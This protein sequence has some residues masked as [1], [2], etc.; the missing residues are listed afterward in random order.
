MLALNYGGRDEILHA[1]K[2]MLK[3]QVDPEQ[4]NEALMS[5][6]LYTAGIP[7]PDLLI[8]TSGEERISNF[9]TWQSVY[10]ELYFPEVY[11]PDF[12]EDELRKAI[13][14]FEK[15]DQALR[16]TQ[17]QLGIDQG[18][19]AVPTHK[20]CFDLHAPRPGNDLP[21]RVGVLCVHRSDFTGSG[22]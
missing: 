11:W 18:N 12:G 15:R 6:Y 9:L 16:R 3:D 1:V 8:R 19:Y 2:R 21:G 10:S 14:I 5:Q 17:R 20:I 4:V 22:L 13:E 7:D